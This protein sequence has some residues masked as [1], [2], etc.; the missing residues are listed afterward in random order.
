VNNVLIPT[1]LRL[2][3]KT[4]NSQNSHDQPNIKEPE[5]ETEQPQLQEPEPR[6]TYKRPGSFTKLVQAEL[7][8]NNPQE[9][10]EPAETKPTES[11]AQTTANQFIVENIGGL[12]VPSDTVR[13]DNEILLQWEET[14]ND[15]PIAEVEIETFGGRMTQCKVKPLKDSKFEGKGI[16]QMPEKIQSTL[17]IKKGELVRIRP[18]VP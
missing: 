12:L 4:S 2:I 5:I 13:V 6:I 1:I 8:K 18:I 16:V 17:E 7:A 10:M 15:K 9:S 14:Y 11:S 3:E